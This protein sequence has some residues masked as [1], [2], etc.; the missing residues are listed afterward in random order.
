MENRVMFDYWGYG[1]PDPEFRVLIIGISGKGERANGEVEV[2][3]I[4]DLSSYLIC[5]P[6]T[7]ESTDALAKEMIGKV[8]SGECMA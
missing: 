1:S 3:V 5:N 8:D 6:L 7:S 4:T 2:E